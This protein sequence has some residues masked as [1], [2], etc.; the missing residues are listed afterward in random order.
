MRGSMMVVWGVLLLLTACASVKTTQ[1]GLTKPPGDG[2]VYW[3][4]KKFLLLN[5]TMTKGKPSVEI[6]TS[7]A[8]PDVAAGPF[9]ASVRRNLIG[10]NELK[11]KVNEKGLLDSSRSVTTS[12][13]SNIF[14]ELAGIAGRTETHRE[15]QPNTAALSCP[16]EIAVTIRRDIVIPSGADSHQEKYTDGA[17]AGCPIIITVHAIDKSQLLA[18]EKYLSPQSADGKK[19]HGGFFYRQNLPYYVT[20]EVSN[21]S[22]SSF[23]FMPNS[24]GAQYVPVKGSLFADNESN[25][26]FE[27]GALT[28]YHQILPGEGIAL[29][30]LPAKILKGY[31]EAIGTLFSQRAGRLKQEGDYETALINAMKAQLKNENCIAALKARADDAQIDELCK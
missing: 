12:D 9:L 23:V 5:V 3:L 21:L 24:S 14:V 7:E 22:S 18:N 1:V 31:F 15:F 30:Q 16:D 29:V 27:D 26:D 13:L 10:R 8:V 17:F 2:L 28:E 6:K 19:S 25:L 20:V 11:I 4:P